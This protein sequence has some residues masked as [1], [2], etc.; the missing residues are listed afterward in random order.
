MGEPQRHKEQEGA[1]RNSINSFT[2]V[3]LLFATKKMVLVIEKNTK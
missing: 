3:P 1:Q 2:F